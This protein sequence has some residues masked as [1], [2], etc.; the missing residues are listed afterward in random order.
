MFLSATL[1]WFGCLNND[2]RRYNQVFSNNFAKFVFSFIENNQKGRG[3]LRHE[4]GPPLKILGDDLP[5]SIPTRWFR[6]TTN[7]T[8]LG[9]RYLEKSLFSQ[10]AIWVRYPS[11]KPYAFRRMMHAHSGN[12]SNLCNFSRSTTLLATPR[13]CKVAFRVVWGQYR[14]KPK[15]SSC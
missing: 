15:V 4:I 6:K 2:I 5:P 7:R 1:S 9:G 8:S 3:R 12:L 14:P 13:W 10:T 11:P